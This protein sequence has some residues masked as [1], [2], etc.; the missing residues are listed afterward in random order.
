LA[1]FN[2]TM[3]LTREEATDPAACATDSTDSSPA[4]A[5]AEAEGKGKGKGKGK[6]EGEG[7]EGNAGI[8]VQFNNL[9]ATAKGLRHYRGAL[10]G[11]LAGF[12]LIF[13][14]ADHDT[15]KVEG[16]M[17]G[18]AHWPLTADHRPLTTAR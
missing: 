7:G 11:A 16:H 15:R 9:L 4:K 12:G 8:V 10:A 17:M 14:P 13:A 6:G 2:S 1:F 18:R 5:E 3:F